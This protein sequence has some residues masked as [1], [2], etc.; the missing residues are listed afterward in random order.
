MEH[1][2]I[3]ADMDQASVRALMADDAFDEIFEQVD[4][5]A[6]AHW[7]ENKKAEQSERRVKVMAAEDAPTHYKML[8]DFVR[9][10]GSKMNPSDYV[11]SLERLILMS[12]VLKDTA[13][14]EVVELSP[15]QLENMDATE[16]EVD[17]F[18]AKL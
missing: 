3:K 4:P 13:S 10:N 9:R 15:G 7:K 5:K 1:V 12:G 11:R 2:A 18:L 17:E 6:F 14:V 8:R 16:K